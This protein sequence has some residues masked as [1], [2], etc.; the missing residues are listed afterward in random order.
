VVPPPA[1]AP[2][3]DPPEVT[4]TPGFDA[5]PVAGLEDRPEPLR[6]GLSALPKNAVILIAG[7]PDG[8]RLSAGGPD[9]DATWRLTL[10]EA[11]DVVLLPPPDW[12]GTATLQVTAQWGGPAGTRISVARTAPLTVAGVAD[13]PVAA[14][15]DAA[16]DEDAAIPLDLRPR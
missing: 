6:L 16:G 4:A 10:A 12:S 1:A 7:L 11:R 13:A 9:L 5:H 14:A 3:P 8:A 2:P 15:R